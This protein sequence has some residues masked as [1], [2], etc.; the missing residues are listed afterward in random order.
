[1]N[2]KII[3]SVL[4]MLLISTSTQYSV[5][6]EDSQAISPSVLIIEKE[7]RINVHITLPHEEG[8]LQKFEVL[9]GDDEITVIVSSVA[10]DD[11]E[12]LSECEETHII[13]HEPGKEYVFQAFQKYNGKVIAI[14][15]RM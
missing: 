8:I 11:V 13:E 14:F 9:C 10:K 5:V 1:M 3:C 12:K 2:S 15:E 7:N 6:S 4:S